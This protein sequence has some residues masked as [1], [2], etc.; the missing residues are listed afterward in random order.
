MMK[1]LKM[2]TKLYQNFWQGR[3][4]YWWDHSYGQ[5][6][7]N[8]YKYMACIDHKFNRPAQYTKLQLIFKK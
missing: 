6:N 2:F 1:G 3:A 5:A 7:D 4:N 8:F